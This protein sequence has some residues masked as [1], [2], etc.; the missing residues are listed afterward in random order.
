MSIAWIYKASHEG[1]NLDD[2]DCEAVS[3]ARLSHKGSPEVCTLVGE[4]PDN[5]ASL[6]QIRDQDKELKVVKREE[7]KVVVYGAHAAPNFGQQTKGKKRKNEEVHSKYT[8]VKVGEKWRCTCNYCKKLIQH[9]RTVNASHLRSHLEMC[10]M[11]TAEGRKAAADSS[12]KS[13]KAAK[14]ARLASTTGL[15]GLTLHSREYHQS[16]SSTSSSTSSSSTSS[17]GPMDAYVRSTD[18]SIAHGILKVEVEAT[19]ARFEPLARL[20]DPWVVRS[21]L[22]RNK[23]SLINNLFQRQK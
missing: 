22:N 1:A 11:I 17:T 16:P 9:A 14:Q 19:I 8:K 4:D 5:D 7:Y 3:G 12:Q 15:G 6:F 18:E 2:I 13:T 10:S 20:T 21:L 23:G